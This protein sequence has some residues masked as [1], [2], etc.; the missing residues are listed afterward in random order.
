[1][2]PLKDVFAISVTDNLDF[3]NLKAIYVSGYT[4]IPVYHNRR[5]NLVGI[6]IHQTMITVTEIETKIRVVIPRQRTEIWDREDDKKIR[7]LN[8]N[9]KTTLA[10]V[11]PMI[12]RF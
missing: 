12:V 9:L 8:H 7:A 2:T 6:V 10:Q 5:D 4:R 3:D 1:M 11:T